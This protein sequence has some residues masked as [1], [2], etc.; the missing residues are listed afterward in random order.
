MGRTNPTF[1]DTLTA[2]ERQWR[3]YRHALRRRDQPYF[4]RLFEHAYAHADAAGH[5]NATDPVIPVLVSIALA[6]E[7]QIDTLRGRVAALEAAEPTI[8]SADPDELDATDPSR[9]PE[10]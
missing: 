10:G 2:L 3:P 5:L 7:R 1:R 4:D 6:Q 9:S 8:D